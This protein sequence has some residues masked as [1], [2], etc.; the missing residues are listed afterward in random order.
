V[1]EPDPGL[2]AEVVVGRFE[3]AEG[4]AAG[5]PAV[6]HLD[7]VRPRVAPEI[8]PQLTGSNSPSTGSPES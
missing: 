1:A 2:V 6:V 8:A 4:L 3:L 7:L 5:F